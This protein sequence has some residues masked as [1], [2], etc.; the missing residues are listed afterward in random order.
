MDFLVACLTLLT[1][2]GLSYQAAALA[3]LRFFCRR[4]LPPLPRG[5]QPGITLLKPVRGMDAATRACLASFI[6]QD[7]PQRQILFGVAAA[8]D[9]VLPILHDLQ[10]EYA[11]VDLKIILCPEKRGLN[12]KVSTLR[13]L[14][15]H[16]RYDLLVISDSDVLAPP[17]LLAHLAGALQEPT[18][19]L[20][21]CLYRAG[22][23]QTVGSAL[24]ALAIHADFI[25]S[26]AVAHYLEGIS[27][28]LGAV[29]A[30]RR[31]ALAQ[32]GGLE[33]LADYLADDYQL[34]QRVKQA[35]WQ[36]T[37]LPLVVATIQPQ[38]TIGGFL[39]HQLRWARTYRVCRPRGFLGYG[40]TF[41]FF[42]SLVTWWLGGFSWWGGSLVAAAWL[43][44]GVVAWGA[45]RLLS[46]GQPSWHFFFL[47]PLKD[48]LS[49]ALWVLSFL[50]DTVIWQGQRFRVQ[51]DGRLQGGKG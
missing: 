46:A 22:P 26:V 20:T 25:P 41:V 2:A 29:M 14:L 51:P 23:P 10:A 3:A 32:L 1:C 50:G 19:G 24:E 44:R 4:S 38:A 30:V 13:Q 37:I 11:S 5:Q 12:P 45:Q 15:P 18:V 40:V 47:L 42:W 9:P 7:Y 6:R 31:E 48:L 35:G 27:F 28:A 16:A 49:F 8:D 21:S 36:V 34:G 33:V 17:H 39:A 43:S